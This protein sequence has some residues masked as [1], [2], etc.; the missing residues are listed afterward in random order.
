MELDERLDAMENNTS[1]CKRDQSFL[2]RRATESPSNGGGGRSDVD[3]HELLELL[4]VCSLGTTKL[5]L[6]KQTT[7]R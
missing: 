5:M 1:F 2:G 7:N 3:I 6:V 4:D